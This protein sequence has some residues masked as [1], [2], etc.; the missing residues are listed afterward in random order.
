LK[1]LFMADVVARPNSGAAGTEY[2][3]IEALRQLGHDVEAVWSGDLPHKIEHGNLHYLLELPRAYEKHML[4]RLQRKSFDIVHVNQP[5][6]YR[7]ARTL[8]RLKQKCVFI[9]RS[10]GVEMRID[11]DLASWRNKYE[12]DGRSRLRK[13]AGHSMA[14]ALSHNSRR[15][16]RYADGHIVSASDCKEFLLENL[17]VPEERIAVIPQAAPISF[18]ERPPAAMTTDRLSRLLYVGQYAFFKAPMLVAEVFNWL[19]NADQRLMFTW[20]CASQHH[21]QVR[22]LLSPEARRRTELL[23]WMP[24]EELMRIYDEHGMFL[25]PSFAEGFGKVFL[26]AMSRGLCVMAAD[27]GGAHD[28]IVHGVNGMLSPTGCVETMVSNCLQLA[29]SSHEAYAISLAA[30][31]SA[32][33]YSWERVAKETIS[34]YNLRLEAK[35]QELATAPN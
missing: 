16:A 30:A 8:T 12:Q 14:R 21:V 11:R 13:L 10:H 7:A 23:A 2:Q 15:I 18:L 6:G 3:T 5:H 27:N 20:V 26:E 31:E 19:C 17:C 32:R 33:A 29:E 9:H 4:G 28:V 35:S 24:Q 25:F 1:I 34:F 22:E